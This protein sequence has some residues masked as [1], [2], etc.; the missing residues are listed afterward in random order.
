[1]KNRFLTCATCAIA[2][3]TSVAVADDSSVKLIYPTQAADSVELDSS[4]PLKRATPPTREE[5][6]LDPV[7]PLGQIRSILDS[8]G[9]I[10]ARQT[11]LAADVAALKRRD[12]V[13][14]SG[15]FTKTDGERLGE[16]LNG[17]TKKLA[18]IAAAPVRSKLIDWS[19]LATF[20]LVVL[21]TI[22]LCGQTIVSFVRSKREQY[23]A[24]IAQR[25]LSR[26]QNNTNNK[27]NG[28]L[29]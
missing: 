23:E 7:T 11:E 27:Q 1:M 15:L 24:E 22:V 25:Y 29:V 18:T 28:G 16:S 4:T 5:S 10:E 3:A 14:V 17:A 12:V 26:E 21:Q 2:L 8:L 19:T 9:T 20:A 13:D 6:E